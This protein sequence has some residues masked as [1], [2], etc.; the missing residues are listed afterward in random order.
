MWEMFLMLF[1]QPLGDFER[2]YN[3]IIKNTNSRGICL[4]ANPLSPLHRSCDVGQVILWASVSSFVE[5]V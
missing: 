2:L 4:L 1:V 5:R 3:I